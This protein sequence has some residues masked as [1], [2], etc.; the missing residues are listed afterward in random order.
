MTAGGRAW[1]APVAAAGFV[2]LWSSGILGGAL[3]IRH[4]PPFA[5]TGL[6]FAAATLVLALLA[7][8]WRAPWPRGAALGHA[9][10]VGLLLQGAHHA[11]IYAGISPTTSPATPAGIP[12]PIP[13]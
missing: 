11:G 13:A 9:V 3:A 8:A 5:V 10:V 7:L 6:R 12:S 1:L 4:G 2:P